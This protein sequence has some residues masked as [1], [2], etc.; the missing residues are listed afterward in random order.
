MAL[1]AHGGVTRA[2][3]AASLGMPDEA[4]FRLD[5]AYGAVSVVDWFGEAP[6]VRA[7]NVR[8]V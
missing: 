8:V 3:V 6:V 5:H 1:V 2:I 4:L 7:L